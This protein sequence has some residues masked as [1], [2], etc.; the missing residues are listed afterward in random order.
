MENFDWLE[1]YVENNKTENF[2]IVNASSIR[3]LHRHFSNDTE[4]EEKVVWW[5]V[6]DSCESMKKSLN[7]ILTFTL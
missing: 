1:K 5:W 6:D 2:A 7:I 3:T 4:D